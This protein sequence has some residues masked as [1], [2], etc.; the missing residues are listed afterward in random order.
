MPRRVRKGNASE[1][2]Q[3]KAATASEQALSARIQSIFKKIIAT[4]QNQRDLRCDLSSTRT[5]ALLLDSEY[6]VLHSEYEK[7]LAAHDKLAAL[8]KE[9]ARQNRVIDEEAELRVSQERKMREEI[10][11]RFNVAM[12]DINAKLAR[13]S[14]T[15]EQRERY[16]ANLQSKVSDLRERHDMR[17]QHFALQLH[18]KKLE[19]QL[20]EARQRELAGR[21]AQTARKL[22]DVRAQLVETQRQHQQLTDKLHRYRGDVSH[23]ETLLAD[24]NEK[25]ETQKTGIEH[26]QAE[27]KQL[28]MANSSMRN[29]ND[30]TQVHIRAMEAECARLEAAIGDCRQ[31]ERRERA[32]VDALEKLCRQVTSERSELHSEIVVMQEAWTKLKHE[33]DS[34]KDQ[35]GDTGKVF[36]VLQSIMN[37]ESL[38]VAVTSILKS[39][40]T[41]EDVIND[42]LSN[43]RLTAGVKLD[44]K[45]T[46]STTR[47]TASSTATARSAEA[48][49]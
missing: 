37:R 29:A 18:R 15:R 5:R 43:L 33:I 21:H 48:P 34:L 25:F 38:D 10:V 45:R 1:T 20:A 6:V 7:S 2:G 30:S 14:S 49:G 31:M 8:S 4:L 16:V 13:Q 28:Q 46:A 44:A 11:H 27:I 32:K 39:G 12:M 24:T 35:V 9:L 41:I 47:S 3:A 22:S 17:G 23:S 19:T 36:D 42:E 40:K 26:V